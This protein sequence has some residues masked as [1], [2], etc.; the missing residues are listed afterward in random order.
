M[1]RLIAETGSAVFTAR[2]TVSNGDN[3][4]TWNTYV[5]TS[6]VPLH[7]V[8]PGRYLLSVEA[9]MRGNTANDASTRRET[10]ITVR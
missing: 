4:K 3:G 2:D 7:D 6:Q 5:Y 8:V 9:R 10:L 1:T